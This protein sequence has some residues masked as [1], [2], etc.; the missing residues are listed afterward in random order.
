MSVINR[1]IRWRAIRNSPIPHADRNYLYNWLVNFIGPKL[2]RV[3]VCENHSAPFDIF[4]D[5][6]FNKPSAVLILG[7][8]GG[9]KSMMS[10]L[11][12]HLECRWNPDYAARIM[13]GSEQQS[14]QIYDAINDIVLM[15]RGLHGSD[16]DTI[17]DLH[18]KE[19]IYHNGS[20]VAI[21]P[22]SSKSSRGPHVPSLLLDEIDEIRRDIYDSAVGM[23][24]ENV[25]RGHPTK[26]IQTS[27]WHK[28]NGLMG[29]KIEEAKSGR[30][31][32]HE[33]CVFEVLERCPPARSGPQLEKCPQCPIQQWCHSDIDTYGRGVPKAK[34]SKGH[35]SLESFI[36]KAILLGTGVIA[37]DYLCAG[38][39][40]EG[41]WFRTFS[42]LNIGPENPAPGQPGRYNP[43]LPVHLPIDYGVHT[44]APAFQIH[45]YMTQHG[46]VEDCHIF[47]DYYSDSMTSY[48]N[49]LAILRHFEAR[50]NG[51]RLSECEVLMDPNAKNKNAIGPVGIAEYQR[52]G[53]KNIKWWPYMQNRKQD[54]LRLIESFLKGGDGKPHLFINPECKTT[55]DAFRNYSRKKMY[56]IYLP[57]PEDPQHPWEEMIDSLAGGLYHLYP[58][59]RGYDI[60]PK[61]HI[62][63]VT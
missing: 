2:A 41:L 22:A 26:I 40:P 59:G 60:G 48:D 47:A 54:A 43:R 46:M 1:P 44:G 28:K 50:M 39:R 17:K 12:T 55:I 51:R 23:A 16:R 45:K 3:P 49:G 6:Y 35:Y 5:I 36:Q 34:R 24:Q 56:D 33:F 30:F 7:P 18:R 27:T 14:R 58:R 61:V 25:K 19:A 4:A 63:R 21:L 52:A 31:P 8:R 42:D 62:S 11:Q 29:E 32:F 15:G 20:R 57:V 53:I 37:A 10:A 38:P 13:G 9:G